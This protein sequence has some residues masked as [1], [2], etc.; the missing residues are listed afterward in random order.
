MSKRS[1][2]DRLGGGFLFGYDSGII[3]GVLTLKSFETDFRYGTKQAT[4]NSSLAV[5]LQTLGAFVACFAI[6]PITH[7]LGRR[8]AL[9]ICSIIF[10]IGVIIQTI[11]THSFAAFLVGRVIAGIGLGG[12]SVVVPMFNSEMSPKQIRGQVG[13]FFQLFY[14]FGIFTSY[15]I[16]YGV[17][18]DIPITASRQW[19]IPVGLQIVPAALLG[20]GMLTL[21]ESVRW[22]TVKGRHDEAW[23][24]LK[25]I[26]ADDGPETQLEMDEIRAGVENEE[27]AREGFQL[28][29]KHGIRLV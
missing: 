23:E 28:K 21:K 16:D 1:C 29:G 25:W 6:W 19:Q 20:L 22:L 5:S 24:S 8:L 3:G 18:K 4:R 11:N 10:C 13:S 9:I 7:R 12:S 17:S 14:T 2:A 15:W 26:R 27:R